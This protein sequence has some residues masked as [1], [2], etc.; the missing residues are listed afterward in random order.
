M[1]QAE[2]VDRVQALGEVAAL[3]V[4]EDP[5]EV[6]EDLFGLAPR[7]CIAFAAWRRKRRAPS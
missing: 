7:S 6:R 5:V 4:V 1:S 2:P 3:L